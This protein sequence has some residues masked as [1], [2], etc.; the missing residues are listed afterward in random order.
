MNA[1]TIPSCDPRA[2]YL[3]HRVEIDAAVA[4]VLERGRYV[5][6]E[7][8]SAFEKEFAAYL[9]VA[10]AVG[11]GS[12]TDALN[13]ALRACGIGPGD[14]VVTVSHTAVATVAAVELSGATPVLIDVDP[15]SGLLDPDQLPEVVTSRT[16]AILAVHLYGLPADLER[17]LAVARGRHLRVIEDCAQSHGAVYKGRR[18]GTWGDIAAFSFYPTKNLG[19]FGDGGALVT[20]NEELASSARAIR[21]Y[22]WRQRHVSER[23]GLNSRLDEIQAA[24]L[25]VKLRY[26]DEENRVRASLA[27]TYSGLLGDLPLRLPATRPDRTHV[28][29]QYVLRH[30]RRDSLRDYLGQRGIGT[31][32]HYPVPVH[33]QP[34]YRGRIR[35]WGPLPWTEAASAEVLSLP[36]Y[37]ELPEPHVRRVAQEIRTWCAML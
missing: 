22:G 13:L 5:L 19:A 3:A 6:G 14:E 29:H 37:P 2:N 8:V 23:A 7:E 34:A 12:G 30:P 9:G 10:N 16:K 11:V 32:V 20:Q 4:R 26:L 17:I 33:L 25:R 27:A 1:P 36:L 15:D 28:Y 31:N 35:I 24:A 21:E 18:A